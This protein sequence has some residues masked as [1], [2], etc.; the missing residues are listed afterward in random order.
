MAKKRPSKLH[1]AVQ[2]GS[3]KEVERLVGE[4]ADLNALDDMDLTPLMCACSNGGVRGM[5]IALRLIE[6]GAD[7]NY[8]R[9][10]DDMTA[11][12]FAACHSQPQVVKALLRAGAA[13][14]GPKG[15]DQTPLMLAARDNNVEALKLL[16]AAGA[17][18]HRPCKLPWAAGKT[19]EGL[20]ELERRRK[21]AEY[22]R[23]VREG[24]AL[25]R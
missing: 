8:V 9:V 3:L 25:S 4:G 24:A 14:E 18:I 17:D 22:L 20:A 1:A 19:A 12:G 10:D 16:I 2:A 23:S 6:A 7:V 15:T 11:I 5:N 13:V 21:A